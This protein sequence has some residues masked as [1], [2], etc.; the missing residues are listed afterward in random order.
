MLNI[1]TGNGG[2]GYE[3]VNQLAHHNAR[4]YVAGRSKERVDQAIQQM[5]QSSG[6]KTLDL[7]FLQMELQDLR[8][9]KAAAKTFAQ[10]ESRLH[11]LMNNAGVR[12]SHFIQLLLG[13]LMVP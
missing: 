1:S 9:V 4:V 13:V 3:T 8:S 11:I 6:G 12:D 2:I 7:H 5:N 10:R